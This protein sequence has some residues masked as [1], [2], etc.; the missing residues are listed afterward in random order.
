MI[1]FDSTGKATFKMTDE[2]AAAVKAPGHIM[3]NVIPIPPDGACRHPSE[4]SKSFYPV[5]MDIAKMPDRDYMNLCLANGLSQA[6]WEENDSARKRGDSL[7]FQLSIQFASEGGTIAEQLKALGLT[8]EPSGM[9]DEE[10]RATWQAAE[11]RRKGM[12]DWIDTRAH[13]NDPPKNMR[14]DDANALIFSY[15][16]KLKYPKIVEAKAVLLHELGSVFLVSFDE[17]RVT[18]TGIKAPLHRFDIRKPCYAVIVNGVVAGYTE[19]FWS[20]AD[21]YKLILK[22]HLG[23]LQMDAHEADKLKPPVAE[24]KV[25]APRAS[26]ETISA[27][28]GR[29]EELLRTKDAQIS[30]AN[31][32]TGEWMKKRA[33][34]GKLHDDLFFK[35]KR[36]EDVISGADEK[37][38]ANLA[39][40]KEALKDDPVACMI[41]A[42]NNW[43]LGDEE[44]APETQPN[45]CIEKDEEYLRSIPGQYATTDYNN[46]YSPGRGYSFPERGE[47]AGEAQEKPSGA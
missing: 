10:A 18:A 37:E 29:Y 14:V 3:G 22:C 34:I 13:Q 43:F 38:K 2:E 47:A 42:N 6:Q 32:E 4:E 8:G 28:I 1:S 33:D 39:K 27:V 26:D 7:P 44:G 17:T 36:I 15:F 45:P 20:D 11:N 21:K 41:G 5:P 31:T 46:S 30:A 19:D 35:I 40:A 16:D 25:E 12:Q 24:K 23:L 9:T